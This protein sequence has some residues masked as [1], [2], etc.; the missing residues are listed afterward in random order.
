MAFVSFCCLIT[1]LG[2]VLR[3]LLSNVST[4]SSRLVGSK[5]AFADRERV[6]CVGYFSSNDLSASVVML[7]L[8]RNYCCVFFGSVAML[9]SDSIV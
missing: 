1:C 9:I 2:S 4:V 7:C 3:T 5:S 8:S 6:F